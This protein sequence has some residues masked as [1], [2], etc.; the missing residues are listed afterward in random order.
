MV[1]VM[2]NLA[3]NEW[4]IEPLLQIAHHLIKNERRLLDQAEPDNWQTI[5]SFCAERGI[6]FTRSEVAAFQSRCQG[7]RRKRGIKT[8]WVPSGDT[9]EYMARSYPVEL[10]DEALAVTAIRA[11]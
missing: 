2:V 8:K 5:R 10:L 6:A 7:L 1:C 3:L 9:K 4:G 11:A